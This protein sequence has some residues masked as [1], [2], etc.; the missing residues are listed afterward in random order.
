M[1]TAG[2]EVTT[3]RIRAASQSIYTFSLCS[4]EDISLD[5]AFH[6]LGAVPELSPTRPPS[7]DIV[8]RN[9]EHQPLDCHACQVL[10]EETGLP[11]HCLELPYTKPSLRSNLSETVNEATGV[12]DEASSV[13]TRSR[14]HASLLPSTK[15]ATCFDYVTSIP[16]KICHR[17]LGS[18]LGLSSLALAIVSLLMYTIHS[19]RMAVWTTRNDELQACTGLIQVCGLQTSEFCLL[20]QY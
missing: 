8:L 1:A 19:Y 3:S 18:L 4:S 20:M 7:D 12:N 10:L 13:P 15:I 14:Y 17:W 5:E 6:P 9:L 11:M 16:S 2:S